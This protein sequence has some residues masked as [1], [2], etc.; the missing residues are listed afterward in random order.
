[1]ENRKY[2]IIKGKTSILGNYEVLEYFTNYDTIC[3]IA[4]LLISFENSFIIIDTQNE[5]STIF[6]N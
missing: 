4:K 5:N 2:L 1:M 6:S 3:Y